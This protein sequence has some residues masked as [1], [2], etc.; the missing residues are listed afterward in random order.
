[1]NSRDQVVEQFGDIMPPEEDT[2]DSVADSSSKELSDAKFKHEEEDIVKQNRTQ[3]ARNA[4]NKRHSKSKA[5]RRDSTHDVEND[6]TD[7]VKGQSK[8]TNVQR[9][10]NRQ[11]AA[12]C[13][14]K[15]KATSEDMHEIHHEGSKQN[16]YL[17]R[18]MRELR[19]Q[20]AQQLAAA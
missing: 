7:S 14:A 17:H 15:K 8:S 10:K 12:K 5:A 19:D 13:R 3:R 2:S 9:E 20:K 1:V 11:A 16:S 18:E 4:A 6:G